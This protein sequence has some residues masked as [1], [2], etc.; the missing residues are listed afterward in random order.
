[1]LTKTYKGKAIYVLYSLTL[2]FYY[3]SLIIFKGT[4]WVT[5]PLFFFHHT[6]HLVHSLKLG[7]ASKRGSKDNVVTITYWATI[8]KSSAT[9]SYHKDKAIRGFPR[10]ST[11]Y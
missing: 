11:A 9:N 3:K 7:F 10:G 5:S 6:E 4:L 1:M 2:Q 8:R